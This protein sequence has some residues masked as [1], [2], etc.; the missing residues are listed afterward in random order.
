MKRTRTVGVAVIGVGH[1]GKNYV[2]NFSELRDAR[3]SLCCDPAAADLEFVRAHFP[4]V[5][6]SDRFESA[7]KDPA[8]DAV[9]I[10]TPA[11]THY[12]LARRALEAG[13][14]VLVEKPLTLSVSHAKALSV[15]ARRR[16]RVLMV[17]HTF[18]FN[19][20]V[21]KAAQL[22]H[23]GEIG[24]V[25]YLKA[26]RSHLGL[27]R[28]DVNVVWDLATHDVSVF[29]YLLKREPVR[30]QA[31]GARLLGSRQ[32][33]AAFITLEY[34][35]ELLAH[36]HVSWADSNK[37]RSI[38][39]VGSKGRILFNDLDTL[40]PLRLFRRGISTDRQVSNFGEFKYLLRDG[41]IVS[42]NIKM[43]EPLRSQCEHF[44]DCI[45]YGRPPLTDATQGMSVV[46]SM[47]LIQ[48]ALSR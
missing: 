26:V 20:A 31:I 27:I 4:L 47:C 39:I 34:G 45:R 10:A 19:A 8:T 32:E 23:S 12:A 36:I 14:H 35:R 17:G 25:Y 16:G 13:K 3:L 29:N 22:V 6:T 1:W 30:A 40:E 5:R 33:D 44:I 2:R 15:L 9:V 41:D 28:R 38:E 48:K 24:R 42:P 37:Q 21:R 7:L 18:L 11:S 43:K 46:K